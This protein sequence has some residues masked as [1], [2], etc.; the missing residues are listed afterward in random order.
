[1]SA[2]QFGLER[3]G[4]LE[5]VACRRPLSQREQRIAPIAPG[6][7]VVGL[8]P[9]RGVVSGHGLRVTARREQRVCPVVVRLQQ[10]WVE[11]QHTFIARDRG[12]EVPEL[13]ERERVVVAGH[14]ILRARCNGLPEQCGGLPVI[15]LL[16]KY[17]SEVAQCLR[18]TWLLA[19]DPVVLLRGLL[20]ST[21]P[22]EFDRSREQRRRG[23][24]CHHPP[25]L[26]RY[27]CTASLPPVRAATL[28]HV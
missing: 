4:L 6:I 23:I 17:G 12:V 24:P 20:Q 9:E 18:L 14:G 11:C 21:L 3:Y 22:V 16:K 5:T 2:R 13:L 10:A 27:G 1:M 25:L 28:A 8:H 19:E 26:L 15:S 7:C